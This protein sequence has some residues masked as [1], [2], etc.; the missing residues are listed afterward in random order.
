MAGAVIVL[1]SASVFGRVL[2]EVAAVA[3]AVLPRV[4]MPLLVMTGMMAILAWVALARC[5]R[6]PPPPLDPQ[7]PSTLS[8]AITFGLLYAV[9]LLAVAAARQYFGRGA[10]YAVAAVSGLT[11]V[12]AIT[13]STSR[14]I[15]SGGLAPETGWR[16]ILVGALS[17]L[18]F[19]AGIVLTASGRQL[20]RWV[21]PYFGVA[22][23]GGALLLVFW[24]ASDL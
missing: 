16:T 8:S 1:A 5:R 23:A 13:L 19:K 21:L 15:D 12:D 9:V 24:P 7:P 11:D 17:N 14:L 18:A 20:F 6:D 3:P 10:L 4:A 2:F 22:L